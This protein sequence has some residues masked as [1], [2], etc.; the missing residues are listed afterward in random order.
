[1]RKI[2]TKIFNECL[3]LVLDKGEA[4][5]TAVGK[6]PGWEDVLLEDVGAVLLLKES[7]PLFKPRPG[8]I[9]STRSRL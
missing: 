1:M 7:Q 6:F 2:E 4:L 3:S 8:F 5:E 9:G